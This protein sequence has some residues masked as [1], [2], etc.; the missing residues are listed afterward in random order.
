[1]KARLDSQEKKAQLKMMGQEKARLRQ[2]SLMLQ[3]REKK[4]REIE[5]RKMYNELLKKTQIE[6]KIKEREILAKEVKD[7]Q[8][9]DL[10][11]W[12]LAKEAQ[13]SKF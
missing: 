8:K 13:R 1:M 2:K 4:K 12:K 6:N 5:D 9:S 7:K 3:A 10:E 11:S